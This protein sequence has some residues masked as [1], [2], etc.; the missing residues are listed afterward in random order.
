L[1][2]GQSA[3][4]DFMKNIYQKLLKIQTE[5]KPIEKDSQNPHFKNYY[6]DISGLLG[7]IK[8]ILTKHGVII[9][10]PLVVL[11]G[12]AAIRTVLVDADSAELF[13]TVT[14]LPECSDPQKF[15]AAVSYF[16]RYALTSL[17]ALEGEDNDAQP[18]K[19][20]PSAV[21]AATGG[22]QCAICRNGFAPSPQYPNSTTCSAICGAEAKRRKAAPKSEDDEYLAQIANDL[23]SG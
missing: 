3:I 16:R 8:P 4:A 5:I 21:K 9:M 14:Y 2:R 20:P 7:A 10:Q 11:D 6:F 13:E 17:L 12:K 22:R 23:S 15:G 18:A 1:E 19:A